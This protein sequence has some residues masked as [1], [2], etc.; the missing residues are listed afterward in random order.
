MRIGQK[1]TR[2]PV[3]FCER[4]EEGNKTP[5]PLKGTVIYIHPKGR[6]HTVEFE[7]RGGKIRE[8]FCG[9]GW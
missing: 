7:L 5:K 2:W 6:F 4:S 8:S 9:V 1:V 3:G